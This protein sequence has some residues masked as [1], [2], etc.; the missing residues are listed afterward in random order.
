MILSSRGLKNI[1]CDDSTFA[2]KVNGQEFEISKFRAQ[3]ISP[4]VSRSLSSDPTQSSFTIEVPNGIECFETILSL[5][6]GNSVSIERS[7]VFE[8]GA[9]CRALGNEELIGLVIGNDEVSISNVGLRLSLSITDSDVGFACEHFIS[10]DHSSLPVSVL[11]RLLADK[12]LKI[13]SEDWLLKVIEDRIRSDASLIGLL[14]YI[15][16]IYLG[17]E[18]MSAFL[19]LISIES[20]SSLVWSSL[21][22]RLQLPVSTSDANPRAMRYAVPLNPD[23]RFDGVFAYLWR[24]CGQNPHTAGLVAI[25]AN[26]EQFNCTLPRHKL[27]S[28]SSKQ[29]TYWGTNDTE[30]DHYVKID[31]K[32][33]RLVPPGYSV[34]SP[35]SAWGTPFVRSWRFEGSNDDLG[36]EVLDRHTRSNELTGHDKEASFGISTTTEFRFLRFIQTCPHSHGENY[37]SLQRLEI[38]GLL[39][40]LHH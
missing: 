24:Q 15:E 7:C 11:E 13:V 37:F 3:F 36:W 19:S 9:V 18:G 28:D 26:D 6:E 8:F 20:M 23:R 16:C 40:S 29:G 2:F 17:A 39:R 35:G 10:L 14:G 5:C 12:R 1:V 25:S 32:S 27:I 33:F 22:R 38:F 4:A 31:L 34:K 21:C 30:V